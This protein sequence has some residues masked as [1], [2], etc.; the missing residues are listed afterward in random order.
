[1]LQIGISNFF[2]ENFIEEIK[3]YQKI[4]DQ[5]LKIVKILSSNKIKDNDNYEKYL[6]IN[7]DSEK[8][9]LTCPKIDYTTTDNYVFISF[10]ST[11]QIGDYSI[12]YPCNAECDGL[13]LPLAFVEKLAPNYKRKY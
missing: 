13:L 6:F 9:Y 4:L 8:F 11:Y 12:A 5:N 10:N 2:D 1:M 7:G 3:S